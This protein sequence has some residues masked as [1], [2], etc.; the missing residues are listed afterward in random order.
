MKLHPDLTIAI[1]DITKAKQLAQK[2]RKDEDFYL[3]CV[4]VTKKSYK[5]YYNED[6]FYTA[7]EKQLKIS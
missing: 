5:E 6:K 2:L 3:Y 7:I 1:G 4:E